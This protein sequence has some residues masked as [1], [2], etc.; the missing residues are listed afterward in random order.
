MNHIPYIFG[1]PFWYGNIKNRIATK[2]V[3]K[4]SIRYFY[5]NRNKFNLSIGNMIN[6]CSGFN[7]IVSK[8]EPLYIQMYGG[9]ILYDILFQ[10]TNG[11]C[12]L[13]NCGIEPA[14]SRDEIEKRKL[15]WYS[16]Y[17]NSGCADTWYESKDDP[18]YTKLID[19]INILKCGGHIVDER[20]IRLINT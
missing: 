17:V 14:Q 19:T 2:H 6:D 10:T 8:I 9:F 11:G 12:S 3:K 20:G 18:G 4:F 16:N 7:G 1:V 5:D 15:E 13:I